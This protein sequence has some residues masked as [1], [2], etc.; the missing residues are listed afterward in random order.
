MNT[1]GQRVRA[2]RK[3]LKLTQTQAAGAAGLSQGTWSAMEKSDESDYRSAYWVD[4]ARV[5]HTTPEW[6]QYGIG[7][8]EQRTDIAT[9]RVE[10]ANGTDVWQMIYSLVGISDDGE[11]QTNKDISMT[12]PPWMADH[13]NFCPTTTLLYAVEDAAAAPDRPKGT[14]VL[15]DTAQKSIKDADLYC[16][17]LNGNLT[18]RRLFRELDES[19]RVACDNPNKTHF[20]DR[21]VQSGKALPFRILGRVVAKFDM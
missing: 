7:D 2:R 8:P 3:Q 16:V 17:Y 6:L 21:V 15:I 14:I 1:P 12:I 19:L 9:M 18:L 5:L 11:N 20:P 13:F 10:T 4:I